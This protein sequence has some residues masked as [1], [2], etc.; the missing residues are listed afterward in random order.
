MSVD[1]KEINDHSGLDKAKNPLPSK[2]Y[3]V[4]IA[5]VNYGLNKKQSRGDEV[6]WSV[7]NFRV[8]FENVK[9]ANKADSYVVIVFLLH[10]QGPVLFCF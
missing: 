6:A 7:V 5:D 1:L 3:A 2:A 4:V 9:D 10:A 8:F